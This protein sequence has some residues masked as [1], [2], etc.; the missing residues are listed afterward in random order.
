[1]IFTIETLDSNPL[2]LSNYKINKIPFHVKVKPSL[3]DV[4]FSAIRICILLF[5]I[6]I[7]GK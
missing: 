2:Q 4:L 6:V 5:W 7:R 3:E 1:M